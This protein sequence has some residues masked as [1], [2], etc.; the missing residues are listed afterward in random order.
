M[1]AQGDLVD[2]E[3]APV[4][5]WKTD[6]D[7]TH[8]DYAANA[9]QI[10]DDL[11]DE[12]PVAHSDRFGGMWLPTRHEDIA[13]IAKNEDGLYTSRGVVVS[14][15]PPDVPAPIGYAP[16]ITSDAP[17]HAPARKLLLEPF[18][19]RQI[20]ALEPFTREYCHTLMDAAL[21][22]SSEQGW[23]DAA[24]DYAQNIPV[25]VIAHMLGLPPEDGDKFRRFI[26]NIIENPVQR[27]IPEQD[28]VDWYFD[29]QIAQRRAN[30]KP[31]GEGDLIDHLLSV[32]IFGEPLAQEH[33]RG[34][35]ILLLVAGIDTT[36]SSI[37]S[38]IWHLAQNPDDLA[39]YRDDPDVRSF[40][41]EEFLRAYAPVTMARMVAQDHELH[42]CP[43]KKDDWVLLSF[44][45]GNRDP[46]AFEDADQFIIDRQKN[47]H[48]AFGLGIHRC[49]GSNLARMELSVALDV[50]VERARD[51]SLVDPATVRF[52]TGQ[53]RG[54]RELAVSVN[55]N[56]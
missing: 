20:Q 54:P 24:I 45:A 4:V 39:R 41:I 9:H 46:E 28:T 3:K 13:A 22:K 48:G 21:A 49:L 8:P 37:G 42:G 40:A 56:T 43:M 47:R 30:P 51:F 36:W 26:H 14:E 10:W 5:D 33:V 18:A 23:F 2:A 25:Q 19:P 55:P 7:H 52:S 11:R 6:F 31:P 35:V 27:D 34:T 50:F 32:E 16:P 38:A 53:I 17:F 12:C 15:I 29:Q 1:A 44:P